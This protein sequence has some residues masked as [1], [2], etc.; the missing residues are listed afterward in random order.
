M[1]T[2]ID[3]MD[4]RLAPPM[5]KVNNNAWIQALKNSM[6]QI[7]P[8]ILVSSLVT[9]IAILQ[10]FIPH[11]PDLWPITNYTMG[12]VGM[13]V[14]F[15]IPFNYIEQKRLHSLRLIAGLTSIGMY[16]MVAHLNDP[17]VFVFDTLGA[18]GMFV[19]IVIG[20]VAGLIFN[21]FGRFSF[22]KEDSSMPDFV[23]QWFDNMLPVIVCIALTWTLTYLFKFDVY[24]IINM[25][26]S[27]LTNLSE[28]LFGFTLLYFLMCFFYTMGISV[29]MIYSLIYPIMLKGITDNAQA[30][31][32]G[33]PAT[34]LM[35]SEVVYSGWIAIGG[36]GGTLLLC[37]LFL[38]AKSRRLKALGKASLFPS[39][40]NINEPIIFGAVA[41]NPILMIPVWIHGLVTPIVTFLL[42]K[43]GLAAI[44]SSI[45]GF[46]Y[47]PFPIS[48]WLVSRSV[49]GLILLAIT[50]VLNLA[51][52]YPFFKVYDRQQVGIEAE[53]AKERA[54]KVAAVASEG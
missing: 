41:W 49:G 48:T 18:G 42:L 38:F 40:L 5:N 54:S 21:A 14:A 20:I 45:F 47:C 43:A 3:W 2:F 53:K 23:R 22:F 32:D 37:I 26:L 31:A 19:A 39:I 30:V 35:T 52:F 15:L 16:L 6:M 24:A 46:W 44:P 25:A 12:I 11:M 9:I 1:K 10:D 13:L 34:H 27:P 50:V 7:L 33:L 51:I 29:W 17:E 36:T 4:R 8:L 28:T